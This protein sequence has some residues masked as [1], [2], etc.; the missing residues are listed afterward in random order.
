VT[1]FL[2]ASFTASRKDDPGKDLVGLEEAAE[3]GDL[4]P[5]A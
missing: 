2:A 3:F 1:A 4:V 5:G